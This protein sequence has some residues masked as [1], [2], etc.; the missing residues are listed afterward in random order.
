VGEDTVEVLR[1]A[2]YSAEAIE[3][4]LAQGVVVKG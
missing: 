2:G 4:L 1:E 3:V